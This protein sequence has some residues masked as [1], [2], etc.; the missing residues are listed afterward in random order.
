MMCAMKARG[1][2]P[3]TG[4]PTVDPVTDEERARARERFRR[5]L[6]DAQRRATPERRAKLRAAL[7]FTAPAA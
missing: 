4:T 3:V 7:G 1:E 5:K 2:H 6:A